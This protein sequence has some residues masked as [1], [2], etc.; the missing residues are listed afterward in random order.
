M[1][2]FQDLDNIS[3]QRYW[4]PSNGL[5]EIS[6]DYLDEGLITRQIGISSKKQQVG[7]SMILW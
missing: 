2:I 5:L 1:K 7:L 3:S 4:A 6:K